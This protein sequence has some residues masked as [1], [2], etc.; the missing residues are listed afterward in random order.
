M[1]LWHTSNMAM[2]QLKAW[3]E[4]ITT[5]MQEEKMVDS[6]GIQENYVCDPF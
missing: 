5:E 1:D 4:D 3:K 2:C 6:N